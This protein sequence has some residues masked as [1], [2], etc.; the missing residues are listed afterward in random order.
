[1]IYK[2]FPLASQFLRM[3][4]SPKIK[5]ELNFQKLGDFVLIDDEKDFILSFFCFLNLFV[6][7]WIVSP[8][9]IKVDEKYAKFM[10]LY[11]IEIHL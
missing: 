3:Q 11:F 4:N 9:L 10:R 1:M 8:K 7:L 2:D 6:D 5:E